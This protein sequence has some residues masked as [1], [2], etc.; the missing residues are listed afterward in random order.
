LCANASGND[1]LKPLVIG[2]F[3]NPRC[4]KNINRKNL[5][6]V[7]E[8]NTKAW[9]TG[10][11]FERWL[12]AF[13][14]KMVGRKVILLMDNAPSHIVDTVNL[15]NTTIHFLPPNTTSRIQ[16]MDAGIIMSFKRHYRSQFVKW[17][18]NRY[19]S[20][21]NENKMDVLTAIQFS[22]NAW[23][24]VSST[25]IFNCFRHTNILPTTMETNNNEEEE[26][27]IGHNELMNELY[28]NIGALRLQNPMEVDDFINY[29]EENAVDE[30]L[31]DQEIVDLLKPEANEF[32]NAEEVNNVEEGSEKCD[33]SIEMRKITN[34]EALDVLEIAS[35]Y[36][37]QQDYNLTQHINIISGVNRVIRK[38]QIKTM[39]QT[40]L[41]LFFNE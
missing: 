38:L 29:S 9:M 6:V 28:T 19:E 26:L 25:T 30:L 33:N 31:T 22:V 36:L 23:N 10:I 7:Y 1:K 18:L 40:S 3:L 35:R 24:D 11:V 14:L 21:I 32:S 2:K 34:Q 4:F 20:G 12:K 17:L 5:G 16:P 39:Q 15:R 13:D 27:F 37:M 8:A 41:E